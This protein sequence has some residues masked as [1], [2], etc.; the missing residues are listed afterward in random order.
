MK[1]IFKNIG[2]TFRDCYKAF[3][4]FIILVVGLK[5]VSVFTSILSMVMLAEILELVAG[6]GIDAEGLIW[7]IIICGACMAISPV[8]T[9]FNQAFY[10]VADIKGEKYF[11]NQLCAFSKKIELSELENPQI[12]DR[13]KKAEAT[14]YNGLRAHFYF[15][16]RLSMIV[17]GIAGC[18]GAM[19]VVG[20][21]SPV[22]VI[23]GLIGIIPALVSKIYFEKLLTILRT[24]YN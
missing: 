2:Y 7:R 21:Y 24:K 12:L 6:D 23:S 17:T 22:L 15:I 14:S 9:V 10:S 4:A 16:D 19:A 20:S 8:H 13:F 18:I 5:L 11:G 3:P 1:K